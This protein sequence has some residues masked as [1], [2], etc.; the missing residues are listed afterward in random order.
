[1]NIK[2]ITIVVLLMGMAA[3]AQQQVIRLYKDKAPGSER[4]TWDEKESHSNLFN[5][6]IVYNVAQPTLTV[7][8]AAPGTSNG[9]SVIIAPGGAFHTLSYS[10]E[11][12]DIAGRLNKKG[13]TAFVL[14]YRVVHS[15]TD[16]P[17][18]ELIPKFSDFKKLDQ[19][20]DSVVAMAMNDGL[21]AMRY[22]RAHA[23]ALKI[24]PHKIGFMG[25]SAGGTV[26]MC[27]AYNGDTESRPDFIAPVYAYT[28]A[29][30]GSVVPPEKMPAFIVAATDDQLVPPS[31][32]V[33][34]YSKWLA[35]KQP[36]ELHMY[37]KGGHGFGSKKQHIPTDTWLDRFTEWLH[38]QEYF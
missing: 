25:F 4:W 36:A 20:N 14:K 23:A 19:E 30:I 15:I 26:T 32:S 24:N 28:T 22:V 27:V 10:N 18:K 31:N 9:T 29:V 2:W 1:M 11:G 5:T 38:V 13:I 34:I 12:A 3:Q 21:A 37:A 16:D 8:P 35:A 33:D 7:Y 17:V 6:L